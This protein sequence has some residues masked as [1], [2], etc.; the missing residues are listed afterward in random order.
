MSTSQTGQ[1]CEAVAIRVDVGHDHES[2][3]PASAAAKNALAVRR[4][5]LARPVL[6][7]PCVAAGPPR[8][9]RRSSPDEHRH[10]AHP[11]RP[12]P[13]TSP[14]RPRSGHPRAGATR[15]ATPPNP[16]YGARQ[17]NRPHGPKP[18]RRPSSELTCSYPPCESELSSGFRTAQSAS[19]RS[20][21]SS[22]SATHWTSCDARPG[23]SYASS[24]TRPQ[25]ASSRA[26]DGA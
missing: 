23:M 3:R 24:P 9:P 1:T 13:A 22:S 25:P 15:P 2:R 5:S 8:T 17:T 4:I 14:D 10:C 19:T 20:T 11:A 18:H 6:R 12:S 16:T 21:P 7:S 26:P